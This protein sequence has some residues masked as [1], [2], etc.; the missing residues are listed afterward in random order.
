MDTSYTYL[1]QFTPN[2]LAAI[3][4]NG[5]PGTAELMQ[6]VAMLAELNRTGGRKVPDSA[7]D[8]FVPA[9]FR[10]YL[11]KARQAGDDTAYRHYRELCVL[12]GL[13]DGLRSGD[14]HVPGSRRYADPGTYLF[15]PA[16]RAP[17]QAEFCALAGKP[18]DGRRA[19]EHGVEELHV[20]VAELETVLAAS[21][22]D[23]VGAVRLDAEGR[24]VIPP[25]TAEDVP[26]PLT[27]VLRVAL[28]SGCYSG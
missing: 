5:G 24:L 1:R 25:L 23:D 22:P 26:R 7:P 3:D 15:T 20:A 10:D 14:V 17:R 27:P 2:V 9:R 8:G 12:L 28:R 16:Q 21:S 6:A 18:A 13:R 4:F 19:L 11:A